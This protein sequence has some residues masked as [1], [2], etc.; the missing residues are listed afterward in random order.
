MKKEETFCYNIRTAWHAISRMYNENGSNDGISTSTGFFLLNV[1][2]VN[3]TPATKIGPKMG[4]ESRSLTR[5]IKSLEDKNW[6]TREKDSADK[7]LVKVKLTETG[8]QKRK[9]AR[10]AVTDFNKSL[11]E[12][13]SNDE[14]NAFLKVINTINEELSTNKKD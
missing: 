11:K 2:P 9:L 12:K 3:G 7:R 8:H 10:K 14:M 4:L 6:I 5:V 13:I 1:D